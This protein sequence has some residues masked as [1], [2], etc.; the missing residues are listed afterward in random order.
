MKYPFAT[1]LFLICVSGYA[2]FPSEIWHSGKVVLVNNDTIRGNIKYDLEKDIIQINNKAGTEAYTVKKVLYFGFLDETSRSYRQFYALP[3]NTTSQYKTLL[4]FEVFLE[5]KMTLL[6]REYLTVKTVNYG[7]AA[8]A[9]GNYSKQLLAY[10]YYFLD[11]KGRITQFQNKKK[12]LYQILQRKES[13]IK[14]YI[15]N[16]R[17]RFDDKSEM[18]QL[19]DYYNILI[20]Q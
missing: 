6:A 1:F 3:F 19:V 4:F 17:L 5:G 9:G 10:T 14:R 8:F 16:N 2:Q 15:K 7:S 13:S 18:M 11:D 12:Q 20:T